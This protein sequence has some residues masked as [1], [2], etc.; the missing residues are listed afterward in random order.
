MTRPAPRAIHTC[1]HCQQPIVR[2]GR[3]W[4][5]DL[6]GR[7]WECIVDSAYTGTHAEPEETK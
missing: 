5:H 7:D 1:I 4:V 2:C 6:P 3:G